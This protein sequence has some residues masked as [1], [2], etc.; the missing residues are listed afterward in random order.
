MPIV[1]LLLV[2]T[3]RCNGLTRFG[4]A[5]DGLH[6]PL[7]CPLGKIGVPAIRH[8]L[9]GSGKAS[10]QQRDVATPHIHF[11]NGGD[12]VRGIA[13]RRGGGD[14]LSSCSLAFAGRPQGLLDAGQFAHSGFEGEPLLLFLQSADLPEP[15]Q[16]VR[17]CHG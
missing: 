11:N 12:A 2:A 10:H 9:F 14:P 5:D 1:Q 8:P 3:T 16:R 13:A 6:L 15:F 4:C 7:F 17:D